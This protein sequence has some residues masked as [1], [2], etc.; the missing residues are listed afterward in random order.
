ML[1]TFLHQTTIH[2]GYL[3]TAGVPPAFTP[4]GRP[5]PVMVRPRHFW[6][7]NNGRPVATANPAHHSPS[8]RH[9]QSSCPRGNLCT[10]DTILPSHQRLSNSREKR[11][12]TTNPH[13]I[14]HTRTISS[15]LSTSLIILLTTD[16]IVH[17]VPLTGL[18]ITD[19]SASTQ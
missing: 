2:S 9:L 18:A 5:A 14:R 13:R 7:L 4:L 1:S 11:N 15:L 19:M 17:H 8:Q 6:N 10:I 3:F 12:N 16:A